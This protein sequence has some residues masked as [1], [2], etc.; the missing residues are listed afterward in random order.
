MQQIDQFIDK[1]G[2]RPIDD[3]KVLQPLAEKTKLRPSQLAFFF[4]TFL[5]LLVLCSIWETLICDL[6]GFVYPA[7][8]SFKA[9][10]TQ[11]TDDDKQWLTYWVVYS[12]FTVFDDLLYYLLSF[13]P[14]YYLIKITFYVYMFHPNIQGAAHIYT[15]VLAPFLRKHQNK[16]DQNISDLGSKLTELAKETKQFEVTQRNIN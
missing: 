4:F 14:F 7:Y 16:I 10:E 1:A 3:L 15:Q 11:R 9:L 13:I 8:M 6:V 12:F 2:L 5:F